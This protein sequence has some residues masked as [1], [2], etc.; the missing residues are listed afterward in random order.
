MRN[1]LKKIFFDLEL[2][3]FHVCSAL[4]YVIRTP[5]KQKY[6]DNDYYYIYTLT[7]LVI[8]YLRF[9]VGLPYSI[10]MHLARMRYDHDHGGFHRTARPSESPWVS[11][12][13]Y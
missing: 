1:F 9:A 4:L 13:L 12:T 11:V 8:V 10:S 2:L 5:F 6:P 7:L 3:R